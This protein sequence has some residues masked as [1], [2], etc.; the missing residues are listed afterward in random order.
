MTLL[1]LRFCCRIVLTR[2]LKYRIWLRSFKHH[3]ISGWECHQGISNFLQYPWLRKLM[4]LQHL[5][6]L[7]DYVFFEM[8][9]CNLQQSQ[10]QEWFS[11]WPNRYKRVNFVHWLEWIRNLG[12]VDWLL[13][14]SIFN[15]D[16]FSLDK[17][18]SHWCSGNLPQWNSLF[19]FGTFVTGKTCIPWSPCTG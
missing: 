7:A 4:D 6:R 11:R 13:S 5:W 12:L 10:S 14:L 3:Q 15:Y 8:I 19:L 9:S 16:C 2:L 1:I 18:C 17:S